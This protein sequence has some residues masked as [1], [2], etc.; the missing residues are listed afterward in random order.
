MRIAISNPDSI[1][2]F[3]LRQPMLSALADHGHELLLIVREFVAPLARLAE[4]G[5]SMVALRP[6]PYVD[7]YHLEDEESRLA[8]EKVKDFQPDLLVAAAYQITRQEEV[9]Q[10][11]LEGVETIAFNGNLFLPGSY[12][13]TTLRR[14]RTV[15]VSRDEPELSKNELLCGAILGERSALAAPVLRLGEEDR[16]G[17]AEY[18]ERLGWKAGEFAVVCAGT[19]EA[20]RTRD[21][22]PSEW[23]VL[24]RG[25]VEEEGLKVLFAGTHDEAPAIERVRDGM[26]PARDQTHSLAGDPVDLGV[27]AAM[28]EMGKIYVGRDTGPMHMAAA[29]GLPVVSLF[30]GGHWPR[31]VP[32]AKAGSVL[33]VGVPCVGCDWRC[34]LEQ[35]HCVKRIPR[36]K[37]REAV[38]AALDG[39]EG[40][41]RV[42][43]LQPTE[44]ALAKMCREAVLNARETGRIA[45]QERKEFLQWIQDK[46]L[47]LV[48]TQERIAALEEG[49]RRASVE[50]LAEDYPWD[51][52]NVQLEHALLAGRRLLA[53]KEMMVRQAEA[54]KLRAKQQRIISQRQELEELEA[55]AHALRD[56]NARLVKERE[57]WELRATDS[58]AEL[59]T[60][61]EQLHHSSLLQERELAKASLRLARAEGMVAEKE[62]ELA[63]LRAQR[64]RL[65]TLVPELRDSLAEAHREVERLQA[66][67][68]GMAG[69]ISLIGRLLLRV[70]KSL[71]LRGQG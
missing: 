6:S 55:G 62:A 32:A 64:R 17:A 13:Q 29:V 3:V 52:T 15:A 10:Q 4:P 12:R 14:D 38:S 44:S 26:G 39:G 7:P 41:F 1:G 23:P 16:R 53:Q 65:A 58:E 45:E 40:G 25:L 33:T 30:G 20:N 63:A 70:R 54:R 35:S 68:R 22:N 21:W 11:A 67:P 34:P 51:R 50:I 42:E 71:T 9:V 60:M 66:L 43:V 69:A 49:V 27:L 48:A 2:D 47:T 8:L 59:V 18:L 19:S 57:D 46:D 56:E 37:V 5:A 24:L 36:G 28:L 61:K 31:F